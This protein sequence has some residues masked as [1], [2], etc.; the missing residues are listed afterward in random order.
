[1]K[2]VVIVLIV[3]ALAIVGGIVWLRQSTSNRS[4]EDIE[5]GASM[6]ANVGA[7]AAKFAAK[8]PERACALGVF[9]GVQAIT[10][11]R[12]QEAPGGRSASADTEFEIG[13]VTKA[14]TGLLLADMVVKEELTLQTTLGELLPEQPLSASVQGVT[15]LQLS[16][17]TSG[18]PRLPPDISDGEDKADP[19]A[20]YTRERLLASLET[21]EIAPSATSDYSNYGVGLLGEVLAI[22]QATTYPELLAERVL[23][24][25]DLKSASFKVLGE[26]KAERL[27]D[28][29]MS[30]ELTP[31]WRL[32]SLAGAGGLRMSM[33][34]LIT[35]LGA[36]RS[37]PE[38]WEAACALMW[39][40]HHSDPAARV[41]LCWQIAG[42]LSDPIYWHNGSTFGASSFVAV[43]PSK[44]RAVAGL[45][46]MSELLGMMVGNAAAVEV[47]GWALINS[48]G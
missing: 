39:K 17:H 41:G 14:F 37:P 24:P 30:G 19:Y 35:F 33:N 20:H 10:D 42:T 25:F 13:S 1:M 15:L 28:G 38:G 12:G 45:Q 5:P 22:H 44:D 6:A 2:V 48:D 40:E 47:M 32:P 46:N 34:D 4:F 29:Y 26:E 43:R 8:Y 11:T 21:L 36:L 16:T 18:L 7:L 9:D 27:I 23:I 3:I 31:H